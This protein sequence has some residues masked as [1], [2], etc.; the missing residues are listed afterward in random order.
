[1]SLKVHQPD[2]LHSP[3]VHSLKAFPGVVLVNHFP[4][5]IPENHPKSEGDERVIDAHQTFFCTRKTRSALAIES[6]SFSL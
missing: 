6:F 5:S 3:H 2:K 4:P 1:M